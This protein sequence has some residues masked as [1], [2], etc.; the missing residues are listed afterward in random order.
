[1]A[2]H[3]SAAPT[4]ALRISSSPDFAPGVPARCRA[5]GQNRYLP[6]PDVREAEDQAELS[7]VEARLG[8][9]SPAPVRS[10][11]NRELARARGAV[12]LPGAPNAR[13]MCLRGGLAGFRRF[14][15]EVGFLG[16][17]GRALGCV[18]APGPDLL[19]DN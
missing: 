15:R 14:R 9:L 11:A 6:P 13:R 18:V 17:A 2:R 12:S 1:M 7:L 19:L 4:P 8:A 16:G 10:W 3:A 5:I